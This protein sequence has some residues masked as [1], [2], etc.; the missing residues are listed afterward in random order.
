M[1]TGQSRSKL[2]GVLNGLL[3]LSI[4]GI[5]VMMAVALPAPP[6]RA[7]TNGQPDGNGHPYIGI[8]V[9]EWLTPGV[10]T[11]FCSGVLVAPQIFL[12]AGH[13]IVNLAQYGVEP[14]EIWISFDPAFD[15]TYS[16]LYHGTGV[17]HPEYTSYQGQGGSAN[18]HDIAVVHL[19]AAPPITL[20]AVLPTEAL[21]DTLD[22]RG[23][24]FTIVGYGR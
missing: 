12:T 24:R 16:A 1:H 14:D 22:L 7:I 13:C 3:K 23:E 9:A 20:G 4:G 8:L 6:A 10:K 15:G 17:P 21:L 5:T 2:T 11:R 18:P 19:D